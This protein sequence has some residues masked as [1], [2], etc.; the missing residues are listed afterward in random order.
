MAPAL[1]DS[2]QD[3]TSTAEQI[4]IKDQHQEGYKEAFAQGPKTTNYTNE[5]KGVGKHPPAS[6]PDYLPVWDN[7]KDLEGGKYPPLELLKVYD[8]GK[9]ADSSF[10]NLLK[11]ATSVEDLTANIGAE[12]KGVQLSK[13]DKAGKDELALFVAQKK[14]VGKFSLGEHERDQLS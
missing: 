12:V 10:K 14:V 13:L 2:P 8:H 6:F 3:S 7:E 4:Y 11:G 5:L 1:I 9:D